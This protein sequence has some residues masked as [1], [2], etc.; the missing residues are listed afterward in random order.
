M[1]MC[2]FSPLLRS[3]VGFDRFTR[4]VE[5]AL[6]A[7]AGGS[8]YPPCDILSLGENHYRIALAVAGF[9]ADD[10]TV[11]VQDQVLTVTGRHRADTADIRYL[12]QGIADQEFVRGFQ[13]ADHV[14]VGS[15]R[16]ADG[17]L[18]IDLE[19]E[20]PEAMKPRSIPVMRGCPD[21]LADKARRLLTGRMGRKAA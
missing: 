7:D 6:R 16:L 14:K 9:D 8:A 20:I 5:A 17:V 12:H 18:T 10:L 13:L 15:A 19:R 4:L 11:E 3:S 1:T 21:S 2:D